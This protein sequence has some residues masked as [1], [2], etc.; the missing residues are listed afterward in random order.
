MKRDRKAAARLEGWS[1]VQRRVQLLS[2]RDAPDF[3]GLASEQEALTA[4]ATYFD[5]MRRL[6]RWLKFN[7]PRGPRT[8]A[9]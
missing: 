7:K 3:L 9:R 4:R 6:K 1:A 5:C 2:E 8:T